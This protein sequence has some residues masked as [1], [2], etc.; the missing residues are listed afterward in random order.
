MRNTSGQELQTHRL[1]ICHLW[2]CCGACVAPR[3]WGH[4]R[5][6]SK[7]QL[8]GVPGCFLKSWGQP[9][10]LEAPR[11]EDHMGTSSPDSTSRKYATCRCVAVSVW[12]SGILGAQPTR[13]RSP[14]GSR[15]TWGPAAPTAPTESMPL[16]DLVLGLCDTHILEGQKKKKQA[17]DLLMCRVAPW[18]L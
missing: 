17:A 15:T 6:I 12:G 11:F 3:S 16:V 9:P 7:Q 14:P 18:S 5:N 4:K 2:I 10:G 8:L 1:N 13:A